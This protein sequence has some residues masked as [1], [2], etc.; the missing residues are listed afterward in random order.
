MDFIELLKEFRLS[1]TESRL[2]L[3]QTLHGADIPMSEK[4]IE[5]QMPEKYNRTTIYRNL[6]SLTEKG[7]IQRILSDEAIKYKLNLNHLQSDEQEH[8]HFQCRRC[9]RVICM[10]EL[11]IQEYELPEGFDKI[12]NQFLIVGI[13]KDCNEK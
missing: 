12:E 4:E 10:E 1:R 3:L 2:S 7:I 11:K 6:N 5:G 13:C 9:N 8:I